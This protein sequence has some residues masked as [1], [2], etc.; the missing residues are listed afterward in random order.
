MLRI[1]IWE[2]CGVCIHVMYPESCAVDV[3]SEPIAT[4]SRI[5]VNFE[6]QVRGL[7]N[8]DVLLGGQSPDRCDPALQLLRNSTFRYISLCDDRNPTFRVKVRVTFTLWVNGDC[9][10]L[11]TIG[12]PL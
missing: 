9:P 3:I 5:L 11:R 10:S 12:G 7:R 2:P 4:A 6:K 8:V 1:S